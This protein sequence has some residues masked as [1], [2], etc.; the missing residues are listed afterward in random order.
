MYSRPDTSSAHQKALL[1]SKLNANDPYIKAYGVHVLYTH[2]ADKH[3]LD[4]AIGV[5]AAHVKMVDGK[6]YIYTGYRLEVPAQ[7][8]FADGTFVGYLDRNDTSLWWYDTTFGDSAARFDSYVI[9]KI[10]T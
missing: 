2:Q 9:D 1:I 6:F 10:E 8:V 7:E 4:T 5:F 3:R